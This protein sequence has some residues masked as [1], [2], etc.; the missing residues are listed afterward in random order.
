MATTS[1]QEQWSAESLISQLN[2]LKNRCARNKWV[3]ENLT[4]LDA[5]RIILEQCDRMINT[6]KD[7]LGCPMT[8]P[9]QRYYS[10]LG[11][12]ILLVGGTGCGSTTLMH[13]LDGERWSQEESNPSL[14]VKGRSSNRLRPT[15]DEARDSIGQEMTVSKTLLPEVRKVY[16]YGMKNK[17]DPWW[18]IDFP[19][20]FS[21]Q[22]QL[23]QIAQRLALNEICQT[24]RPYIV[25]VIP[26]GSSVEYVYCVGD[27]LSRV[28]EVDSVVPVLTHYTTYV[29]WLKGP[30]D[31]I[32]GQ[33][34]LL[35]GGRVGRRLRA[36]DLT[37][38][39]FGY[40][41]LLCLIGQVSTFHP[42]TFHSSRGFL[43][44]ALD[45]GL[46]KA[47][48]K[49]PESASQMHQKAITADWV[50]YCHGTPDKTLGKL[51][52]SINN[53]DITRFAKMARIN[54]A[55]EWAIEDLYNQWEEH[56]KLYNK[57]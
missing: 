1:T 51:L 11:H 26:V 53:D 24:Y 6:I 52:S 37:L 9:N 18:I 8:D 30:E 3:E 27:E 12:I 13:A 55:D 5:I 31:V 45:L 44:N 48:L 4:F 36:D 57:H 49:K 23:F 7:T 34:R 22:G 54:Q 17:V 16:P 38:R 29:P 42:P 40:N 15:T 32:G 2:S 41:L 46:I 56:V 35:L 50:Y 39:G 21:T 20:F 25:Q 19:G 33:E 47:L 43:L 14:W 28:V 10:S